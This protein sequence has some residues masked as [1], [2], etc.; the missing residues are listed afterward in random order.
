MGVK[1]IVLATITFIVSTNTTYANLIVT[2]MDFGGVYAV[3]GSIKD[4]GTFGEINSVEPFFQQHWYAMQATA[5]ITNSNGV[6]FDGS[7]EQGAYDYAADISLM[8]DSQV[9]VGLYWDFNTATVLPYLAVFDC[10]TTVGVCIGQSTG[11]GG[12]QFGGMQSG[13]F[14]GQVPPK[15]AYPLRKQGRKE[16]SRSYPHTLERSRYPSQA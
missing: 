10:V 16:R 14:P 15:A 12:V 1:S 5:I 11:Q 2:S 13:P 7:N 9:A 4:D 6:T 3:E 8:T